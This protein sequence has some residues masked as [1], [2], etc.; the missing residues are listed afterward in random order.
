M[1]L[2]GFGV[3]RGVGD[4]TEEDKENKV[5]QSVFQVTKQE[6]DEQVAEE[7][8][9]W[10]QLQQQISTV[11]WRGGRKL[12]CRNWYALELWMRVGWRR[13][14]EPEFG[15]GV[16]P[17]AR[18]DGGPITHRTTQEAVRSPVGSIV[19]RENKWLINGCAGEL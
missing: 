2:Y 7:I 6:T 13:P 5:E 8:T 10:R 3:T 17:A 14:I 12:L 9:L 16:R 11:G 19:G 15:G 18:D 4:K 1:P